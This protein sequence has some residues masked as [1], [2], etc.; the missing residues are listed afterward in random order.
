VQNIQEY[1]LDM[2]DELVVGEFN[3]SYKPIMDG[4]GVCAENY[5]KWIN[6]EHGTAYAIVPS[7]PGFVDTDPFPVIRV[8]SVMVRSIKPYRV[9]VPWAS[10]KLREF[11]KDTPFTIVHSHTP[12]V[13]GRMARKVAKY[14]GIPHVSTFHTKYRDDF[15]RFFTAPKLIEA[16]V[17][18]LVEFYDECDAVWTP[19]ESTA[20]TLREYGYHG[21]ITVAPNGTDLGRPSEAERAAYRRRGQEL[22]G[23]RDDEFMFL[24]V[25]QHRW[26]KNVELIIRGLGKLAEDPSVGPFACVFIGEGYASED[27]RKLAK[28]V[29]VDRQVRL[30][31]KIVDREALKGAYARAGL[32][33]FPSLYDNAPLVMR[34]AAAFSVPTVVAMGS[35]TAEVITDGDNG[36]VTENDPEQFARRLRTLMHQPDLLRRVGRRA[37]ETIFRSWEEIVGWAAE[38][39]RAIVERWAR[40]S[41]S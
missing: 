18:K 5:A 34:E 32:F 28:E 41:R 20:D 15:A 36:F 25:G 35:T 30:L 16:F 7:V 39:Y 17:K 33:L 23:L 4:V 21:N 12:F 13:A 37:S 19:S 29:G 1:L 6:Q 3:D 2:S 22:A 14:H 26:E 8:P 31:G 40:G 38:E 24:F 9:G 11:L 27:M 10:K